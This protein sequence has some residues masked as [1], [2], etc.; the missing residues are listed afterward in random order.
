MR[1]RTESGCFYKELNSSISFR[2]SG[3]NSRDKTEERE[4]E[5]NQVRT[6]TSFVMCVKENITRHE[7]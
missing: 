5:E 6:S 7:R 1:M 2:T 3:E 4:R